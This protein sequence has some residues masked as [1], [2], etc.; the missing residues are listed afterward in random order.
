M[1]YG[2]G[3]IV[4]ATHVR[5]FAGNPSV[6]NNALSAHSN[7]TEASNKA[8]A[9]WGIGYGQ[10]G[11]GQT[12]PVINLPAVGDPVGAQEW[13]SLFSV[14]DL[15][16]AHQ[17]TAITSRSASSG[18]RVQAFP[19]LQS[20]LNDLDANRFNTLGSPTWSKMATDTRS[21]SWSGSINSTARIIWSSGDNARFFFNAGGR[22]LLRPRHPVTSTPQ[23]T[24]WNNVLATKVG[25]INV[26]AVTV[27]QTSA[28]SS[29]GTVFNRGYYN[30]AGSSQLIYE[31]TNIGSGA[32]SVND[33]GI[34]I[35]RFSSAN[36]S[37]NGDN[38]DTID[39]T[40]TLNDQHTNTFF[41]Q[42]SSGTFWE[43]WVGRYQDNGVNTPLPA[44]V[45][46][47]NA[48]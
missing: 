37:G 10:R 20:D 15:L 24:D 40:I 7:N 19:G 12:S 8:G 31:G 13:D 30:A 32:Y 38:G 14:M 17:N 2:S 21:S 46:F 11:Y 33:V 9:L 47:P 18:G 3:R 48:F 28:S 35:S 4:R 45:S 6:G 29:A 23:D 41:D 5:D 43:I 27:N 42:V 39:I 1:T 26:Y 44:S 16:A 34:R 22:I 36:V 25:D